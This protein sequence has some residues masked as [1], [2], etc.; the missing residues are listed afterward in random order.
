[1][2]N[3]KK[4]LVVEF[5]GSEVDLNQLIHAFRAMEYFG[6]IGAS[7]DVVLAVDGD[8]AGQI[9]VTFPD[10]KK[11]VEVSQKAKDSADSG[12]PVRFGI[13]D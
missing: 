6:Q 3:N 5:V 2:G 4:R 9:A 13:G 11:E 12:K 8:G 1:M 7:R 10:F